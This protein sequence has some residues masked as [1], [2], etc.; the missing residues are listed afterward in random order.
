VEDDVVA[1]Q[2]TKRAQRGGEHGGAERMGA[3]GAGGGRGRGGVEDKEGLAWR[4]RLRQ[5]RR[6]RRRLAQED[7]EGPAWRRMRRRRAD[8]GRRRGRG[9]GNG[10]EG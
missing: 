6:T 4:T 1:A 7:E 3:G 8:E 9:G 10:D 5:C 2:K